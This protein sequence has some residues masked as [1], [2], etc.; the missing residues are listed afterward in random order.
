MHSRATLIRLANP[1]CAALPKSSMAS[2]FLLHSV[3]VASPT[4]ATALTGTA[5]T[6]S[7]AFPAAFVSRSLKSTDSFSS[8]LNS[9]P[10]VRALG[11]IRLI[12]ATRSVCSGSPKPGE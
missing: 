9:T 12:S 10:I 8:G 2:T 11:T 4:S 3:R 5:V 6:F 1:P 7:P